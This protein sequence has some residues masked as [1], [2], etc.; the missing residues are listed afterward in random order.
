VLAIRAADDPS[1]LW[2]MGDHFCHLSPEHDTVQVEI[3]LAFISLD[4]ETGRESTASEPIGR[5]TCRS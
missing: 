3:T 1:N 5:M 2:A 4:Y